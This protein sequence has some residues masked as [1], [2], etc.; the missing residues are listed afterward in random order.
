MCKTMKRKRILPFLSNI[1]EHLQFTRMRNI[2]PK[3]IRCSLRSLKTQKVPVFTLALSNSKI[4][5]SLVPL[6]IRQKQ[7]LYRILV[8]IAK[9]LLLNEYEIV[10][11]AA[12]IDSANWNF[13]QDL[14]LSEK[15][16]RTLDLGK[17]AK[18]DSETKFLFMYLLLLGYFVKVIIFLP[19]KPL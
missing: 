17:D 10:G 15:S 2:P 6:K 9:T 3:P 4:P 12:Q 13:K 11:L 7:P 14:K 16:L 1:K 8:G 19:H 18:I 5:L